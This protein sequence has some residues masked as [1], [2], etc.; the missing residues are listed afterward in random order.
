MKTTTIAGVLMC[1]LAGC[2]LP[3][4]KTEDFTGITVDANIRAAREADIPAR[5]VRTLGQTGPENLYYIELCLRELKSDG[6]ADYPFARPSILMRKGECRTKV[7]HSGIGLAAYVRRHWWSKRELADFSTMN[8]ITGTVSVAVS[9]TNNVVTA[10][11]EVDMT[12][13]PINKT[14]RTKLTLTIDVNGN[15][16][17]NRA[18]G[19][20]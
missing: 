14:C 3:M 16:E 19:S 10:A 4:P 15:K 1:L 6:M 5:G 18:G 17:S 12:K 9:E 7:G 8:A 11:V 2:A 13:Q 20:D